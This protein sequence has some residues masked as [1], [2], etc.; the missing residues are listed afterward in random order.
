MSAQEARVRR[1]ARRQG[2]SVHKSRGSFSIN[3]R[4]EFM[5]VDANRN[6][7]ELGERFDAT[8]DDIERWLR[9]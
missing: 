5:L 4:G 1:L 6:A 2:Y 3:N 7:I 9:E 8:L